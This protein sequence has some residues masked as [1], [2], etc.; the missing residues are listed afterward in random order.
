MNKSAGITRPDLS[1]NDLNRFKSMGYE[2]VV[3]V[4]N[5]EADPACE[6]FN[7]NIYSIDE[8]LTYDNP[9]YRTSHPN[10]R[11]KFDP[12]GKTKQ[13]EQTPTT[14]TTPTTETIEPEQPQTGQEQH[15]TGL[16]KNP[17]YRRWMP[18]LFNKKNSS[19]YKNKILRRAYLNELSRAKIS[20]HEHK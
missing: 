10:C 18:W 7:G 15:Q 5:I 12:Y 2:T 3:F 4:A 6:Q 1:K 13:L 14:Q 16:E 11:C 19:S 9:L 17:W 8:L 20:R